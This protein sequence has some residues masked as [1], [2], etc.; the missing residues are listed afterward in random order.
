MFGGSRHEGVPKFTFVASRG[1]QLK[2]VLKGT[3]NQLVD[4]NRVFRSMQRI[5]GGE[6]LVARTRSNPQ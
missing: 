5:Y 2:W 3:P 4:C 6:V 1:S